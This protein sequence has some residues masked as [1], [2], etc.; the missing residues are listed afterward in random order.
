MEIISYIKQFPLR[1][2]RKGDI[3]LSEGQPSKHLYALVGGYVKATSIQE[4]GSEQLLW[5][6]GRY[7]VVPT[8]HFFSLTKELSFFYTALSDGTYYEVDKAAF[9]AH[10]KQTPTLMSE[11]AMSMSAHYDDLM[12]RIDSVGQTSVRSKVIATLQYIAERFSAD[13]Q[14]DLYK[15]GL[16]LTHNDVAAMVASTRETISIELHLLMKEGYI[17]YDR[18]KFIVH[19][20]KLRE[21]K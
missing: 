19:L 21:A 6:E 15:I 8:E 12:H 11:I 18:T 2:F 7:D 9:I 4:N 1:T 3:L 20:S 16:K 13:D 10:A 17:T 5:I 14:V